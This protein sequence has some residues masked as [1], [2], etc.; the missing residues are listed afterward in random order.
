M[1]L[2]HMSEVNVA[3]IW[4]LFLSSLMLVSYPLLV[5]TD[6]LIHR[7]ISEAVLSSRVWREV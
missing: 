2:R 5:S 1:S 6:A 4:G 3:F 7:D